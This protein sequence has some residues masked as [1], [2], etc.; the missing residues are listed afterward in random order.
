MFYCGV[1][2][3][4]VKAL[5]LRSEGLGFDFLDLVTAGEM[6]QYLNEECF[7]E[8]PLFIMWI[9]CFLSVGEMDLTIYYKNNIVINEHITHENGMRI[10]FGQ[11]SEVGD[12]DVSEMVR[13]GIGLDP[14]FPGKDSQMID[15]R[16]IAVILNF[17]ISQYVKEGDGCK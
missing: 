15:R 1:C 3:R 12:P 17:H 16:L 9:F 5:D 4:V 11:P 14:D 6:K 7:T 8:W 13:S 10:Y 2:D